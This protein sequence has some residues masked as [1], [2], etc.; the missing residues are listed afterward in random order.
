MLKFYRKAS[1]PILSRV[2]NEPI[3]GPAPSWLISSTGR[4]L[5]RYRKGQGFESHMV[6]ARIFFRL[7][8]RN[9]K[10]SV[11]NCDDLLSY[12]TNPIFGGWTEL[13]IVKIDMSVKLVLLYLLRSLLNRVN[14]STSQMFPLLIKSTTESCNEWLTDHFIRKWSV[15]N[16]SSGNILWYAPIKFT[17]DNNW[18][19]NKLIW[20]AQLTSFLK[21][22]NNFLKG[23]N[24]KQKLQ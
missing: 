15:S 3:Q 11:H 20:P 17:S 21:R 5:H 4:T 19:K 23:V 22:K 10:S 16:V 7:S 14:W 6:Q 24:C 9:C 12:N 8:F 13:L 1:W 2:Y 18:L